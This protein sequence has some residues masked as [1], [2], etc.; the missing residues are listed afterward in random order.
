MKKTAHR[1][2]TFKKKMCCRSSISSGSAIIHIL[3]T[4]ANGP[5]PLGT[6]I[7]LNLKFGMDFIMYGHHGNDIQKYVSIDFSKTNGP[8]K[9]KPGT[10]HSTDA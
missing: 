7:H 3:I 5:K 10:Q 9:M 1:C 8:T 4:R 6:G 2:L